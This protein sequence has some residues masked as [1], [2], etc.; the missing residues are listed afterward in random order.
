MN[1]YNVLPSTW[2]RREADELMELEDAEAPH[3]PSNNVL[4]QAK[5][6][7]QNFKIGVINKTNPIDSILAMKYGVHTGE[8]HSVGVDPF[9]VHYWTSEQMSVYLE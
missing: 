3:L 8:I 5:F 4:R 1:E 9:F 2:R 6:E 7:G